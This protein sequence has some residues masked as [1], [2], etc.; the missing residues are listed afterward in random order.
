MCLRKACDNRKSLIGILIRLIAGKPSMRGPI[1]GRDKGFFSKMLRAIWGPFLLLF[2]VYEGLFF[3]AAKRRVREVDHW[4][5][6]VT[7]G[8]N[9]RS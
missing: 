1:S 4:H 6:S 5:P 9:E 2:N 7:G 8:G 3:R